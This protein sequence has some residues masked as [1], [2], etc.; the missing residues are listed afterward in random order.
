MI[1]LIAAFGIMALVLSACNASNLE[2]DYPKNRDEVEA[3]KVGSLTGEGGFVL[4]GGKSKSAATEG[5]NVNAYLW[6][7]TLDLVH[8]MPVMSA[9]PFGGTVIT[10]WYAVEDSAKRRFKLNIYII[11]AE[12][13]SDGVRV[14]AFTQDMGQNG[15]WG[16]SKN[17]PVLARE[18]EDKILIK[19]R[20]IKYK[21]G[22]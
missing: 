8:A 12:L 18:I 6:R 16:E 22:R 20:E 19:A 3:E 5:I 4:F 2:Q 15:M 1:R 10:D 21:H 9:D 7:A 13:R 14:A 11:G 17:N